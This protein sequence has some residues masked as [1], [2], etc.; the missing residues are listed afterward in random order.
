MAPSLLIPHR[1]NA[2]IEELE[3]VSRLGSDQTATSC[4][5]IQML[6]AIAD[7][8]L[9]Y[10]ALLVTHCALRQHKNKRTKSLYCLGDLTNGNTWL[11]FP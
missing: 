3:Q 11:I 7:T 2:S 6:G 8:Q 5:A 4:K 1:E 9:V 10:K